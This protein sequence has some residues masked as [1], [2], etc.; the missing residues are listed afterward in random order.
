MRYYTCRS[1]HYLY[2]S[3]DGE[4]LEY[5]ADFCGEWI[6]ESYWA[7]LSSPR[8]HEVSLEEIADNRICR[9]PEYHKQLLIEL[10]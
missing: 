6:K 4:L 10:F 7:N 8:F 2:R 9:I 1:D 3:P 5:F